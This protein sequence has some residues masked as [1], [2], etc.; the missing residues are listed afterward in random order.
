MTKL[1][2]VYVL[3]CLLWDAALIA[4]QMG[5]HRVGEFCTK[6]SAAT[7]KRWRQAWHESDV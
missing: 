1:D 2:L 3:Y 6:L 7:S 5:L 4:H